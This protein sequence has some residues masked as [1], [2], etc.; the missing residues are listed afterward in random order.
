MALYYNIFFC[1]VD[2]NKHKQKRSEHTVT[3]MLYMKTLCN[4]KNI[5]VHNRKKLIWTKTFD[6]DQRISTV[7]LV[8]HVDHAV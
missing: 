5:H 4:R 6:T 3:N 8:M 2:I 1:H 7:S